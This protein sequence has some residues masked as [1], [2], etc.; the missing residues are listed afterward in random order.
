MAYTNREEIKKA[1]LEK[2]ETVLDQIDEK[3]EALEERASEAYDHAKDVVI[4]SR[5]KTI[6]HI[7]RNPEKS[8]L[9]A[10][11]VGAAVALVVSFL[12]NRRER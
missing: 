1:I 6:N 11:G 4:D 2:V 9:I 12:I 5:K 10:A 3:Y 7:Q 8:V